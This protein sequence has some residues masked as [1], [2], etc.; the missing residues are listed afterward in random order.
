MPRTRGGR[1]LRQQGAVFLPARPLPLYLKLVV[2]SGP[3]Q[4]GD[5]GGL[6]LKIFWLASAWATLFITGN[7]AW[8]W[9]RRRRGLFR[10]CRARV[11]R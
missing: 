9:W 6:A 4:F 1:L 7:G 3:L 5:Y 2:L 11:D 8:L 10:Y